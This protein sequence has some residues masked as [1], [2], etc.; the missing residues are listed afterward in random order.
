MTLDEIK[1]ILPDD[2]KH[3][4]VFNRYDD[5]DFITRIFFKDAI[6]RER[7]AELFDQNSG[8]YFV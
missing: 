1:R 6:L 5:P 8:F 7:L 2:L 4:L 3:L